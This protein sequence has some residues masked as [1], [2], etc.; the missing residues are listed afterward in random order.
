MCVGVCFPKAKGKGDFPHSGEASGRDLFLGPIN[1]A[2]N[3]CS[4][5]TNRGG[6]QKE[7]RMGTAVITDAMLLLS[8]HRFLLL[9]VQVFF[10]TFLHDIYLFFFNVYL[11]FRQRQ[12]MNGGG[13]ERE[14]D[15][16]S[17]T[18]SRL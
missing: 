11:F 8:P 14:G 9:A 3:S 5:W 15:T 4:N 17:E 10:F 16:E 12:S 18:G 1:P 6:A 7:G 2:G 13:S